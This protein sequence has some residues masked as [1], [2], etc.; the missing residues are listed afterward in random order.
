MFAT[1]LRAF[2][3]HFI[4]TLAYVSSS[5]C[6]VVSLLHYH[7]GPYHVISLLL[8]EALLATHRP[9]PSHQILVQPFARLARACCAITIH[10]N[11]VRR[12]RGRRQRKFALAIQGTQVS[13]V[14]A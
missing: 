11:T 4:I 14:D 2:G 1:H 12:E 8:L 7:P 13:H 5:H 6:P 10:I 3:L 9:W